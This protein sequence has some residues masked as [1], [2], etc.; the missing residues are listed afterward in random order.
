MEVATK[1]GAGEAT[2]N[3]KTT[4]TNTNPNPNFLNLLNQL[5]PWRVFAGTNLDRGMLVNKQ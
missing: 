1:S 2:L 3:A 4:K 5:L